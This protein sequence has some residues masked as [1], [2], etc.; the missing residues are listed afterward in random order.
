MVHVVFWAQEVGKASVL[1]GCQSFQGQSLHSLT[2]FWVKDLPCWVKT[3]SIVWEMLFRCFHPNE[4]KWVFPGA[5]AF[6][7]ETEAGRR[8]L[9]G[10]GEAAQRPPPQHLH[11]QICLLG[12]PCKPAE[13]AAGQDRMCMQG[14]GQ[15]LGRTVCC[16]IFY[17][18]SF[19]FLP[20]LLPGVILEDNLTWSLFSYPLLLKGWSISP[21]RRK[22]PY[23]WIT[24]KY[25]CAHVKQLGIEF[26]NQKAE[27]D[28]FCFPLWHLAVPLHPWAALQE[29]VH[30]TTLLRV[31]LLFSFFSQPLGTTS[32]WKRGI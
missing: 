3:S 2:I 13:Q 20:Q 14:Q 22:Q 16:C 24:L 18:L 19:F 9:P 4:A 23:A 27:N 12:A 5:W 21:G 15:L 10:W 1:H 28:F 7:L 31:I 6:S 17:R 25:T 8:C 29:S 30:D 11:F 26:S 32:V